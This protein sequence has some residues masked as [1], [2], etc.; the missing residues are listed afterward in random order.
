VIPA[1]ELRDARPGA[2]RLGHTAPRVTSEALQANIASEH[3]LNAAEAIHGEDMILG[4]PSQQ[5]PESLRL[6]TLC[7]LTTRNG[8]V[9]VGTSAPA[10]P[11]NFNAE[12]GRKLARQKAI[13]QLWPLMGYALR[14]KLS[15]VD[16]R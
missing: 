5:L 7:V 4:R 15:R 14:E 6:L 9:L 12:L 11:E 2:Q 3:Y 16:E 13:D 8:F 1:H 10:S